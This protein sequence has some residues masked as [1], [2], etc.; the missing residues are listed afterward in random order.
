MTRPL[1]LAGG[2]TLS[3]GIVPFVPEVLLGHGILAATA[4]SLRFAVVQWKAT[5]NS[6]G[7][8]VPT[9][10]YF[11]TRDTAA[12]RCKALRDIS[13]PAAVVDISITVP[14]PNALTTMLS[15]MHAEAT[16]GEVARQRR[17]ERLQ[18]AA[19]PKPPAPVPDPPGPSEPID[20]DGPD[21]ALARLKVLLADRY[22]A[23]APVT[24]GHLNAGTRN[25]GSSY[26]RTARQS[27]RR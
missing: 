7:D 20:W 21:G 25:R 15:A 2:G 3:A 18:G 17:A 13:V 22:P 6:H 26:S 23:E 9:W 10:D 5:A 14:R 8:L 19:K 4:E 1:C 24:S 27:K 11:A 16:A 12:D